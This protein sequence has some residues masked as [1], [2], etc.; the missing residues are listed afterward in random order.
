[1][2]MRVKICGLTRLEDVNAAL[3]EGADALGF[4]VGSPSSPRNLPLPKA[5][6]LMRTARV[7]STRVAVTSNRDPKRVLKICMVL[8]PEAL[9][10]HYHTPKLVHLVQK[11]QPATR[12]ILATP[13]GDGSCVRQAKTASRYS[14]AILADSP[15]HTGTGGTGVVHDWNLTATIRSTIYPHPLILAG[16]LTAKNVKAAIKTVKPF[17]VDVSSGVERT[18]GVKDSRKI[19]E[20]IMNAKETTF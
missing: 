9:Q 11:E 1:M 2:K 5:K 12:L 20:F 6:K 13:I 19:K 15:N 14:D 3:N 8:R 18:V 10:L 16:G 7:F 4:V 17:A